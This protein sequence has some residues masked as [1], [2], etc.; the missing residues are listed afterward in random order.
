MGGR[1]EAVHALEPIIRQVIEK[2]EPDEGPDEQERR[3]PTT[4]GK[5]APQRIVSDD[6]RWDALSF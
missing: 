2:L 3:T 4:Y 5:R 1:Y 6:K